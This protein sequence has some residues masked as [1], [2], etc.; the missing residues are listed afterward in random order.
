MAIDLRFVYTISKAY[1]KKLQ[2]FADSILAEGIT[3]NRS[4][5]IWFPGMNWR[6]SDGIRELLRAY[7]NRH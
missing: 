4:P 3:E 5:H 1:R 7:D 6:T 2:K